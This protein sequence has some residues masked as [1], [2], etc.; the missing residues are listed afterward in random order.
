MSDNA[1]LLVALKAARYSG[2]SRVRHGDRDLTFR[3]DAELAAAISALEMEIAAE[4]GSGRRVHY[5]TPALR[6]E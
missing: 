2:H 1:S 3:S 4:S 5:I 6:R